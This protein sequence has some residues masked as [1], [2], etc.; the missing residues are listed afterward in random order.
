[1]TDKPDLNSMS[2]EDVFELILEAVAEDHAEAEQEEDFCEW[3]KSKSP[4]NDRFEDDNT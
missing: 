4:I 1:M 2:V 3:L